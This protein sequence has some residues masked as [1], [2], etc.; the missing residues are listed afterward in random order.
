M[1]TRDRMS[2]SI[3]MTF[4]RSIFPSLSLGHTDGSRW[5]KKLLKSGSQ[6]GEFWKMLNKQSE[7]THTK[8]RTPARKWSSSTLMT[9]TCCKILRWKWALV[10]MVEIWAYESHQ[11]QDH[12]WSL[13]ETRVSSINFFSNCVHGLDQMANALSF[14]RQMVW[15]SWY[16]PSNLEKLA[17]EFTS[18]AYS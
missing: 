6:K 15:A 14:P 13:V 17:S 16:L 3:E 18:A 11:L 12:S 8:N 10:Y 1:G 2:F 7:D 5:Q 4:V 9:S